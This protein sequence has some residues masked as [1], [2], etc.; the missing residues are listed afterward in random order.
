VLLREATLR[1]ELE[2]VEEE[3]LALQAELEM[4]D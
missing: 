4:L 3:W 2:R 1:R